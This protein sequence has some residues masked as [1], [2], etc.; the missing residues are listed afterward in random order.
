MAQGQ[1][2]SPIVLDEY[3]AS[4]DARFLPSLRAFHD[5]KKLVSVVEKW[6]RDHRPWTRQ[7][8]FDY[9]DLPFDAPGHEPV[10]KRLFKHAEEQRDDELLAA[11]AVAFDRLVRRVR[12][13]RHHY[14]WQAQTTWS[15]EHLRAPRDA[16][17]KVSTKRH[18][19]NPKTLERLAYAP[20]A[21][22]GAKLFSYHTRY[23]LRRRAWRHFRRMGLQKPGEYPQA[24]ARALVKYR[25]KDLATGENLLDSWSLLH[26]CFGKSD[27][28]E[29]N[30]S[31]AKVREGRAL[32]ELQAAPEFEASWAKPASAGVLV[33]MLVNAQ[34]RAVR[35]WA[36]QVLQRHHLETLAGAIPVEQI[37]AL[38]DHADAEVQQFG[39]EVLEQATGLEKLDVATWLRMLQ[40]RNLMALEIIARVMLRHVTPDRLT[41]AQMIEIACAT[42]V[43]VARLGLEFLKSRAIATAQDRE[44]IARLAEARSAG[45]AG[46]IAR[47]AL[48]HLGSREH[49]RVDSIV[50]FFDALLE[51]ARDA[52]WEWLDAPDS[53]G[54]DDPALWSR[55]IETPYD[56]VRFRIV[57]AL[58][59]RAALPGV[60]SA[61]HIWSSVLLG[62]HRGGRAKL[63]ALRQI[64]Q[65][66]RRDPAR[67]EVLLPAL[68]VAIR[69]VRL[70]ELRAGLSALLAAVDAHPPL[71]D[72]LRKHLPELD[73]LPEEV[74]S[75]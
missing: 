28:L 20:R 32:G 55:L 49:Y 42:P 7:Q 59:R 1:P 10:V 6:K 52:A 19:L 75:S 38:L 33:S 37:L 64:S 25:D 2:I 31:H 22:A 16:L 68:A 43:P 26:A 11:C 66:I 71:A 18:A 74:A 36:V 12:K 57:D 35:V 40:T 48:G 67:A 72:A 53:P 29:F 58:K 50:R 23:Y 63:A 69:S 4:G 34:A 15:E 17:P 46:D 45:V 70:P 62:V 41:L 39:A 56:D 14:D 27:V 54:R 24:I 61:E 5:P 60:T 3:L 30:A 9:L 65:A 51:P 8:I 44:L 47:W 73:L 13:T 21:R